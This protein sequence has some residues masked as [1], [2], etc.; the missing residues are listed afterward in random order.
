MFLAEL[1]RPIHAC[2]VDKTEP[3]AVVVVDET[4]PNGWTS[5]CE[6]FSNVW[7]IKGK[8]TRST[9]FNRTNIRAC[10]SVALLAGRD[11]VTRVEEENLDADALF[12]YLKLEKY[13]PKD[14]FFT[15]EL[16][17]ASNMAV[18]NSTV[19]R[20]SR[21]SQIPKKDPRM[22]KAKA[23]AY[24]EKHQAVG[25]GKD[26]TKSTEMS[27][28]NFSSHKAVMKTENYESLSRGILNIIASVPARRI[29]SIEPKDA[30]SNSR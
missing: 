1:R 27:T 2:A 19:V 9:D 24:R 14:V 29:S 8:M 10:H 17:C 6:D 13:I 18:L 26:V 30:N 3:P 21:G 16:T 22:K 11:N 5:I 4:A 15:V 20:R 23:G 12:S 28:G 25:G 7:F